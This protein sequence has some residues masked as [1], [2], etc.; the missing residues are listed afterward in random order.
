[1]KLSKG[2]IVFCLLMGFAALSGTAYAKSNSKTNDCMQTATSQY[3]LDQCAGSHSQTA[4]D[5]LAY[6]YD[7]LLKEYANH[8][9]FLKALKASQKAW[10]AYKKAQIKMMYPHED[11]DDA[12]A[13]YGSVFP[14]CREQYDAYL[15]KARVTQLMQWIK[16]TPEGD[17]C[18]GSM[19]IIPLG[20]STTSSS[21]ETRTPADATNCFESSSH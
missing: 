5:K 15:T 18:S 16:G 20:S 19:K 4:N 8:P 6:V 3:A 10:L 7:K 9:A 17:S 13:Y 2:N 21:S 1:M 14:M 12:N 11:D